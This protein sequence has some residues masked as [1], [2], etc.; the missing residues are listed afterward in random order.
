MKQATEETSDLALVVAVARV[1]AY[2]GFQLSMIEPQAVPAG[3]TVEFH[4]WFGPHPQG[5]KPAHATRATTSCG[6]TRDRTVESAGQ[7]P[8]ADTG[9]LADLFQFSI[10]EPRARALEAMVDFHGSQCGFCT[11]GFIMSLFALHKNFPEPEKE[12]TLEALAG[13]LCR[14][15]GYR[16]IIDAA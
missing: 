12:Q 8:R 3:A 11:P 14:C 15:T 9:Q 10:I 16:A 5:A 4:R 2:D 1:A 6:G 7:R 13:N